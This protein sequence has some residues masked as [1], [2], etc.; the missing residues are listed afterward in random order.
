MIRVA[1]T[2]ISVGCDPLGRQLARIGLG[3]SG[4]ADLVVPPPLSGT[5]YDRWRDV[6]LVILILAN[7]LLVIR[8]DH[9]RMIRH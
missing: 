1:D 5:I 8:L 6:P 9:K 2:G 3:E 4:F 7:L